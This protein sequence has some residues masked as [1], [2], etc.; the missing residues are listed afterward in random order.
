MEEPMS[1]ESLPKTDSIEELAKFWDTHDVTDFE[2]QLEEVAEPVFE[3]G[4]K[5]TVELDAEKAETIRRLAKTQ[6]LA[7]TKLIQVWV[8]ELIDAH[9]ADQTT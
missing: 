1:A 4:G 8:D 3:R 5:F 9:R 7:A 6:G 2:D